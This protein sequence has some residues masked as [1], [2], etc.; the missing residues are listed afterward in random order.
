M[1]HAKDLKAQPVQ[2]ELGGKL[3]TIKFD[4]NAYAELEAR[5]GSIQ[6]AMDALQKGS[7]VSL[8]SLLWAGLI[9]EEANL[10]PVT[11]EPVGYNITP[12]LV[13]SW[14]EPQMMQEVSEKLAQSIM[15]A[16]P[17]EA[18]EEAKKLTETQIKNG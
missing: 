9:H 18:L 11:G 4:L 3:R 13:G 12:Y 16:L 6:S 1:A 10:D 8:R 14:I 17:A 5:F 15:S 7:V 2:F